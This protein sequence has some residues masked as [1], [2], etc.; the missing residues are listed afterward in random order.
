[1]THAVPNEHLATRAAKMA[2]R[3]ACAPHSRQ[4]TYWHP[5][6]LLTWE[7]HAQRRS[8]GCALTPREH[9]RRGARSVRAI[10]EE[11][12]RPSEAAHPP[13]EHLRCAAD[14]DPERR[15]RGRRRRERPDGGAFVDSAKGRAEHHVSGMAVR[16]VVHET[17]DQ[18]DQGDARA[19][20]VA[21]RGPATIGV[22][23]VDSPVAEAQA[24]HGVHARGELHA[25]RRHLEDVRAAGG[26]EHVRPLEEAR[27]RLA[28]L[29]VAEDAVAGGRRNLACDAAHVPALAPKRE[30]RWQARHFDASH[31]ESALPRSLLALQPAPYTRAVATVDI[32]ELALEIGFLAGHY[33][34]ADDEREGDQHHQQPEI[35][36]RDSQ[37]DETQEPAEV[38]GVAREAVRSALD[39]GGGRPVGGDVRPGASDSNDGPGDQRQGEDKHDRAEPACRQVD[40]Q[41]RQGHEPVE[42]KPGNHGKPP[43][44]WRPNNDLSGIC[45]VIH[46]GL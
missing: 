5:C 24:S 41:E 6:W 15:R 13:A 2:R 9:A 31:H 28:I 43:C 35:I 32:A 8:K 17:V 26:V 33:A 21:D 12:S 44:K 23:A 27:E 3:L 10:V 25:P 22:P 40:R 19:R 14:R 36:E 20:G 16:L 4:K 46:G 30:V 37:A 18:S 45:R 1:M 7:A 38:D 39:D 11:R 42:R 29:A 34:V